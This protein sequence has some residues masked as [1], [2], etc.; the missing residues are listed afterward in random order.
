MLLPPLDQTTLVQSISHLRK[1]QTS[2]TCR[3]VQRHRDGIPVD[4]IR[5]RLSNGIFQCTYVSSQRVHD[6][7][8]RSEPTSDG[9]GKG[10]AETEAQDSAIELPQPI[11]HPVPPG[12][13]PHGVAVRGHGRLMRKEAI[14]DQ[15]VEGYDDCRRTDADDAEERDRNPFLGRKRVVE[16]V[17]LESEW[18]VERVD[19]VDEREGQD[20]GA[21][22]SRGGQQGST[23]GKE[24]VCL[25]R[26]YTMIT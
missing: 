11:F 12:Q 25:R 19:L 7:V 24:V 8:A 10:D 4:E 22:A 9:E 23:L 1:C 16:R 15:G 14:D 2:N 26:T 21:A 20:E 18:L 13:T 3:Q 6:C 5:P 17:V